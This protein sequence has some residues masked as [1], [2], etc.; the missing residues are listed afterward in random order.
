MAY[1]SLAESINNFNK[2]HKDTKILHMQGAFHGDEH[3]G[4]V[5]KLHKL[6]PNLKLLVITPIEAKDYDK[7]KDKIG[8]DTIVL[9]FDRV[10]KE[11]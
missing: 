1:N 9:T 7:V 2:V 4:V 10:T 8:A 6:N 3:L 5:E 11:K